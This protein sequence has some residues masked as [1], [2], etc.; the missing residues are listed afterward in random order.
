VSSDLTARARIRDAA[1]RLFAD[2]GI[3][4]ATIRD[5]AQA[6]EVSSGLLRHHFGSKEGLREA[7]DEFALER[8]AAIRAKML[9]GGGLSD[10]AF[11]GSA[12]PEAMLLQ[13]YL[14]RSTVDGAGPSAMFE[15]F[16]T[17]GEE[18]LAD[19]PFK[20]KDARTYVA[21]LCAMQMG[22]FLMRDQMS[23]VLGLDLDRPENHARVLRAMV[24]VFTQPLLDPEQ[25]DQAFTALDR[26]STPEE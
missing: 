5:I 13:R 18:W 4:Q 15:R 10:L 7:C 12:Q 8:M 24:E 17:Q 22:A 20:V 25:A 26:L 14:V 11:V 2:K 21:V 6:A 19:Q 1:I 23:H 16:V 3:A 9:Q